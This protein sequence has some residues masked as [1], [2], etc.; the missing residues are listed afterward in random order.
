M[1]SIYQ[2]MLS[3]VLYS[4]G[5]CGYVRLGHL[6]VPNKSQC[7]SIDLNHLFS[8]LDIYAVCLNFFH[9][10]AWK[11]NLEKNYIYSNKFFHNFHLSESSFTC[12]RL[13]ASGFAWGLDMSKFL[14]SR[15]NFSVP[16]VEVN[17]NRFLCRTDN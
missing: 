4:T 10:L 16:K 15:S 13:R 3:T 12:P 8:K 5:Q 14:V 17:T 11:P 7:I 6:K 9:V 2:C 1:L